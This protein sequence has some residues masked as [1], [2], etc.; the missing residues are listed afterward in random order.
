M[1]ERNGKVEGE[2]NEMYEQ[3]YKAY[4]RAVQLDPQERAPAQRLRA[5]RDLPPRARLGRR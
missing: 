4:G 3:S 2:A 1:L 5:D